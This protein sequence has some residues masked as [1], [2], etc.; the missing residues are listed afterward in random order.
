MS[1]TL[2]QYSYTPKQVSEVTG[3]AFTR[4]RDAIA[5]EELESIATSPKRRVVRREQ[6]I[7]WLD[8]LQA[9]SA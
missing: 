3:I 7:A 2:D 4:V 6:L 8:Q 5:S 1:A 9:K